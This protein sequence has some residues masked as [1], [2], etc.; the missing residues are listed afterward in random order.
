MLTIYDFNVEY[1]NN[2][3]GIDVQIP[4]FS[5]KLDSNKQNVMQKTYRIEVYCDSNKVWDTKTI[6][7]EKSIYV[8]SGSYT[9]LT[10][11]TKARGG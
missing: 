1:Q 5:W 11:P 3:V 7:S 6:E 4:A 9:H 8:E 10:L 2:P